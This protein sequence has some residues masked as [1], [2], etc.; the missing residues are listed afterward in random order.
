VFSCLNCRNRCP[1]CQTDLA[2]HWRGNL[3]PLFRR[4]FGG[5]GELIGRTDMIE[6]TI[7]S[8]Q[9]K[10]GL[11]CLY[12]ALVTFIKAITDGKGAQVIFDPPGGP[13]IQENNNW[14]RVL[15]RIRAPFDRD[16]LVF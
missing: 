5:R 1:N 13:F 10:I 3:P 16:N 14:L 4:R 12:R 6:S 15:I 7:T 9:T 8:V 2:R 11:S